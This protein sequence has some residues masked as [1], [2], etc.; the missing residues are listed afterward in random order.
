MK[1]NKNKEIN[2]KAKTY[3]HRK[4]LMLLLIFTDMSLPEPYALRT[5]KFEVLRT[6][7]A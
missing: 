7:V 2:D 4:E 6:R 5:L 1:E 3:G